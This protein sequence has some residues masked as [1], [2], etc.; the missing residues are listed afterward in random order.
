MATLQR[1]RRYLATL[2]IGVVLVG[3]G[4]LVAFTSGFG[5]NTSRLHSNHQPP[6]SLEANHHADDGRL[7]V[8]VSGALDRQPPPM[9]TV[10]ALRGRT[11]V[12]ALEVGN[13]V[14]QF[15]PRP[16]PGS[17]LL[18]WASVNTH[19]EFVGVTDAVNFDGDSRALSMHLHKVWP[20]RVRLLASEVESLYE[21]TDLG[22]R[23]PWPA[24]ARFWATTVEVVT[25]KSAGYFLRTPTADGTY[26]LPMMPERVPLRVTAAWGRSIAESETFELTGPLEIALR[27]H[28]LPD[29]RVIRVRDGLGVPVQVTLSIDVT[30]GGAAAVQRNVIAETDEKGLYELPV[31]DSAAVFVRVLGEQWVSSRPHYRLVPHASLLDIEV[32]PAT[33]LRLRVKYDDEQPYVGMVYI[34]ADFPDAASASSRG[35]SGRLVEST[36][37][38]ELPDDLMKHG[39]S[40]QFRD[41]VWFEDI[42]SGL[43]LRIVVPEQRIGYPRHEQLITAAEV[44][45]GAEIVVVLPQRITAASRSRIRLREEFTASSDTVVRV[46]R[47]SAEGLVPWGS[48]ALSDTRESGLLP[49]GRYLVRV[50]GPLAWQSEEFDLPA[51]LTLEVLPKAATGIRVTAVVK[52]ESGSPVSGAVL[53]VLTR[54]APTFPATPMVG[55]IGVSNEEGMITLTGQPEGATIFRVEAP[56]YQP[57][58]VAAVLGSAQEYSLGEFVLQPAKGEI[59]IVLPDADY[60]RVP[61]TAVVKD[62]WTGATCKRRRADGNTLIIDGLAVDRLYSVSLNPDEGR[63]YKVFNRVQPTASQNIVELVAT[64]IVLPPSD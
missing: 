38:E 13:G 25:G 18:G 62:P 22:L 14:F 50:T 43:P 64:D 41:V 42:P 39:P 23:F 58:I 32:W 8:T 40:L 56:S 45:A 47:V 3:V 11:R 33:A 35:W 52:G 44:E 19:N 37:Q 29:S 30:A 53:D 28:E 6:P 26:K 57:Q 9:I 5:S 10:V 20:L 16:E 55:V 1:T 2:A 61:L 60:S 24:Q 49:P 51:G 46:L 34:N 54:S 12:V 31:E 21:G 36:G 17:T 27:F 7:T 15:D 63:S 48:F 4:A 59:R